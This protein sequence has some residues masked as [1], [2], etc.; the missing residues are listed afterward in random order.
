MGGYTIS[1][2]NLGIGVGAHGVLMGRDS[3]GNLINFLV[4]FL[5]RRPSHFGEGQ[6]SACPRLN[7]AR[8]E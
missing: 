5:G 6:V 3:S 8:A 1:I 4:H 2:S 7:V